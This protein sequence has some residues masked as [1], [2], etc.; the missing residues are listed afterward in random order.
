MPALESLTERIRRIPPFALDVALAGVLALVGVIDLH[1]QPYD[2]GR[3]FHKHWS[4]YVFLGLANLA[5]AIRR[6]KLSVAYLLWV[7]V[8][9]VG[10]FSRSI[11]VLLTS[12]LL[13]DF[14][15]VFTVAEQSTALIAVAVLM[16][17]FAL[18]TAV[19]S[20]FFTGV[21]LARQIFNGAIFLGLV[22]FAGRAARRRKRLI[23]G[24]DAQTAELR[25]EQERLARQG[26]V[27]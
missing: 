15:L 18:D 7:I 13:N 25:C 24:L 1:V 19:V 3:G 6:K 9:V 16:V 12:G 2:V 11:W 27:T 17:E 5:V 26:V 23:E 20:V 22:W 21:D 4:A 8:V 14:V 10:I